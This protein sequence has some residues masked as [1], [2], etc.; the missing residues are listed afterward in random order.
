MISLITKSNLLDTTENHIDINE[1]VVSLSENSG[2]D[3]VSKYHPTKH[4]IQKKKKVTFQGKTWWKKKIKI[5]TN[6]NKVIKVTD[7]GN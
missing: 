6:L 4:W 7:T 2:I 1:G 3:I 5:K